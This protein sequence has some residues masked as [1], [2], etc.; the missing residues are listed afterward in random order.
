MS[1]SILLFT[2]LQTLANRDAE[3]TL[4]INSFHCGYLD[5]F[6]M[7]YS[8]RFIWIPVYLG[9]IVIM[10]RNFPPK[11]VFICLLFSILLITLCDQTASTILRPMFSR[12]RPA[13]PDNP[14]SPY[15]HIVDGYRGGHYGFPS[16]HSANCWGA[17][18]FFFFVFRRRILSLTLVM[19]AFLM[20]WSRIYLGVH[21]LGDIM[22]GLLVGLF[23]ASVDYYIFQL[24]LHQTANQLK[25][26][27]HSCKLYSPCLICGIETAMLLIIAIFTRF[28]F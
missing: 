3:F 20:C 26:N 19:W 25:P 16:A 27:A 21:Y 11:P 9:L 24:L 12:L 4:A 6:M 23:C 5:N 8:G 10:F 22:C 2:F 28:S 13:N 7:M 17:L 15:I 18:F 14:I 1:T